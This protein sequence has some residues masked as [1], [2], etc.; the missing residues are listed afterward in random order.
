MHCHVSIGFEKSMIG[1][2]LYVILK[3][4]TKAMS[5]TILHIVGAGINVKTLCVQENISEQVFR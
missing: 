5:S 4:G 3:V 1:T 2:K